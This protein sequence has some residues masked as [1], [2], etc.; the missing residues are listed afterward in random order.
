MAEYASQGVGNAGLV[1]GIVGSAGWLL[2]GGLNNLFGGRNGI[3]VSSAAMAALAATALK[4][5]DNK[6]VSRH[7][8]TLQQE[9]AA[10]KSRSALLEADNNTDK[11][12]VDVY[13]D[14]NA[15]VNEVTEKL[16]AMREE[17]NKINSAQAVT[18]GVTTATLQCMQ[19]NIATLMG[20][21]KVVI[22][23]GNV[24]PGWGN[25]TVKVSPET[26]TT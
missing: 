20:L 11:K 2:N 6:P 9:L 8:M 19:N 26:A 18:N 23:N 16:Y 22:P 3:D 1:T 21:T 13:K 24:C 5:G 14:I 15:K 12:L 25:V 4:D 7:E 10:E 17:Q